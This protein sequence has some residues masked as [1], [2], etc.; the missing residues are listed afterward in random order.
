LLQ[1]VGYTARMESP[2]RPADVEFEFGHSDT[3]ARGARDALAPLF[4]DSS[5]PIA[6]D[7]TL[8][9]SELVTNVVRHT[10]DGG[11]LSAWDPAPDVPLRLEVS[12]TEP[13]EPKAAKEAGE[14]GGYGLGI[15]AAVSDAWGVVRTH[16]GKVVWAEFDRSKRTTP[17]EPDDGDG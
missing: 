5:D 12:D 10:A 11:L 2:D 7:V 4:Q 3:A 9:A 13:T 17:G 6:E 15:V 8:T 1:P 14:C 16:S